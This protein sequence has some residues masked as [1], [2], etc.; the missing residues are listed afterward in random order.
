MTATPKLSKIDRPLL[1]VTVSAPADE[2]WNAL[3]DPASIHQWFGWDA[4]TLES[5]I[6]FIFVDHAIASDADRTVRFD[7]GMEDRF[8]VEARGDSTL[9]RVV[10]P[11]PAADHDWDEVFEDMT[12]GWIAF[13][14]QL[15]FALERHPGDTRRTLYFSGS[16]R[17]AG[18]P[19]G[20]AALGLPAHA[21]A[22]ERYTAGSPPGDALS[23]EVWHRGRHQ[24]GVEVEAWGDG[25]LIVMDRP[26]SDRWPTGGSQAILTTYGL[27]DEAFTALEAA[28]SRWWNAQFGAPSQTIC[29]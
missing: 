6:K 13:V 7:E 24:I 20:M 29:E 3:R 16:P 28:W 15:K 1:E 10:R 2:V 14:Q 18:D 4:D 19:L 26:A 9:V 12:Q 23:G 22:G 25:L 11:A 17:H 5:E 21:A 27:S 8:E